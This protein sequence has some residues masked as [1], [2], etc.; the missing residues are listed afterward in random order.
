MDKN[1]F[2]D[3]NLETIV[4]VI[5]QKYNYIDNTI[6]VILE[7]EFE[8][9]KEI[10]SMTDIENLIFD[11]INETY[12]NEKNEIHINYEEY[13]KNEIFTY[14]LKIIGVPEDIL[15]YSKKSLIFLASS[16]GFQINYR[17]LKFFICIILFLHNNMKNML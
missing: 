2:V 9:E 13:D 15:W 8:C 14:S 11:N 3:K 16:H 1:K 10:L 6:Y 17:L 5:H 7:L 12:S 4:N